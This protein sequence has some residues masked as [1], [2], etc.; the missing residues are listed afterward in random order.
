MALDSPSDYTNL[1]LEVIRGVLEYRG[2]DPEASAA[3]EVTSELAYE[4]EHAA[5]R[6]ENPELAVADIAAAQK[7]LIVAFLGGIAGNVFWRFMIIT[8]PLMLYAVYRIVKALGL[9]KRIGFF[10]F[11]M[12]IPFVGPVCLLVLNSMATKSL[13]NAGV[14]VGLLG[15][16]RADLNS[17]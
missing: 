2:V 10:M 12:F 9:D 16:K 7:L 6:A 8:V 13:R 1:A 11:A 15:A 3:Q 14:R 5:E 4:L 17:I